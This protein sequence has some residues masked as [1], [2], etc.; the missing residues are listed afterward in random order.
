MEGP[1]GGVVAE[2]ARVRLNGVVERCTFYTRETLPAGFGI[3]GPAVVEEA[4]ATTFIP[5]GWAGTVETNRNLILRR[6]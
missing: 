2:S 5:E 6:A 3:R 1:G 4:T